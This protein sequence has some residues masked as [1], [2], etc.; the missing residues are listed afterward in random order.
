V[1]EARRVGLQG[2]P[3][4]AP[5]LLADALTSALEGRLSGAHRAAR[6]AVRAAI[7][8]GVWQA[9]ALLELARI[10]VLRGRRLVAAETLA[11]AEELLG[12]ARDAGALPALA[13]A[14]RDQLEPGAEVNAAEPL[15]PAELAVLRLLPHRTVREIGE[16][17]YLSANTIKSHIRAIY[18]KFGV[19]TREDAVARATALGLLDEAA[20]ATGKTQ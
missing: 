20:S 4:D 1:R 14:L 19:H 6:Q 2:L 8:N 11:H 15:S 13:S 17:L 16:T 12:A 5:P 18:R 3:A 10:D 7:A 9:W